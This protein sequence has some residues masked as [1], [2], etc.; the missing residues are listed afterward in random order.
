[1]HLVFLASLVLGGLVSTLLSGHLELTM[2]LGSEQFK[3]L[4]GNQGWLGPVMLAAGG[5]LVGFGTRM[6]AGCTSGHGL[7]GVSR[8]QKGSL[9]ATACFFAAGVGVSFALGA[10]I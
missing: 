9:V 5:M 7:C 3:A 4:F 2:S 1:M 10:L 6:A 8:L